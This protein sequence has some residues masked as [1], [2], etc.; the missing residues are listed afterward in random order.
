MKSIYVPVLVLVAALV[1]SLGTTADEKPAKAKSKAL[2]ALLVTGGCCH[3][4]K[5]QREI[6]SNGVSQRIEVDWTVFFEMNQQKS[7]EYLSK[8]GWS[9]GYDFIV[10]NHCFAKET[11][12]AFIDSVAAIHEKGLPAIALHCAMHSYHWNVK[13]EP[14]KEK[15]WPQFLGVSSRGHGPKA[16]IKVTK[17]A[18]HADHPVLKDLPDGWTTPEGELYNVQKVLDSA[19]VLAHG[20]NGKAKQPQVCI[21]VNEYG[22]DKTRVFGTTIGHHNSTMA[23]NEYL[24][25]L[26]NGVRWI[27]KM[28]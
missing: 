9:D 24:D 27:M 5:M 10:Y 25:L 1:G 28:D 2:K 13:A 11:D 21:W 20:E 14:G 4:Y 3:D 19:T 6:I 18:E 23:T 26:A 17:V 12:A 7:K 22:K 16:P 15:T 8:K